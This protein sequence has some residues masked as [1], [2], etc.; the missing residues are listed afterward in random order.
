L[1]KYPSAASD[2][3]DVARCA[4]DDP[5]CRWTFIRRQINKLFFDNS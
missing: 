5:L 1:S 2:N 3:L 4:C